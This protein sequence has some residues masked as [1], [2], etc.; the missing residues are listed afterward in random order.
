MEVGVFDINEIVRAI[1]K[2][3]PLRYETKQTMAKLAWPLL[4]DTL[5]PYAP[6]NHQRFVPRG[7]GAV[8]YFFD[9]EGKPIMAGILDFTSD[10]RT[11]SMYGNIY[12][13]TFRPEYLKAAYTMKEK[14]LQRF[15]N[16]PSNKKL[17]FITQHYDVTQ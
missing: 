13:D 14:F 5:E 6:H 2:S 11:G 9:P 10:K 17:S 4:V 7:D 15:G 3:E 16:H 12:I 1:E 8:F